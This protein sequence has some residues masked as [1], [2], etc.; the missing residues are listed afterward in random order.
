MD[1][2]PPGPSVHGIFQARVV[3]WVAISFS[4]VSSQPRGQ[5]RVSCI[6][7][8]RFT[9]W[10]TRDVSC[11]EMY[12]CTL[13]S[14]VVKVIIKFW[15]WIIGLCKFDIESNSEFSLFY[16][17]GKFLNRFCGLQKAEINLD[18]YYFPQIRT[19]IVKILCIRILQWT[20]KYFCLF[21]NFIYFIKIRV[22]N[23]SFLITFQNI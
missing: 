1:C 7:S 8:R 13:K 17:H 20:L 6:A 21:M 12:Y 9:V 16:R 15:S 14:N 5:T 23:L 10:A 11:S 4:R 19:L 3:E 2:S 18:E 22:T